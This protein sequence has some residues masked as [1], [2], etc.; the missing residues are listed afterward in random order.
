MTCEKIIKRFL[1]DNGYDGLCNDGCGCEIDD[2][3]PCED[4]VGDCVAA[5]A[6]DISGGACEKC[7]N[8]NCPIREKVMEYVED[9]GECA[10]YL[11]AEF[12]P[13]K[14]RIKREGAKCR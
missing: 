8:H 11:H 9:Y 12:M 2:L 3:M 5:Y 14:C 4:P 10:L 6:Y 1:I 7:D 13:L